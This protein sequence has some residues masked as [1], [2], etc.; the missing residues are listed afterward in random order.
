[1]LSEL[2][3]F[4]ERKPKVVVAIIIFITLIFASFI[5]SLKMG[6]STKDFVPDNEMVRA[7]DRINEYFGED[8]EPVMIILY[9][10]DVVSA[11]SIKAE[12]NI[13]K[14]LKEISGTEGVVGVA[15]FVSAICGMEYQKDMEECSDDEIRNAYND[16]M[17]PVSAVTSYDAEDS[18]YDFADITGFEMKACKKS[19]EIVFHVKNLAIPKFSSVEWYVSFKNKV[20]PAKLN[21]SYI[22]SCR[23][24]PP[25]WELGGGMKN[26]E[27]IKNFK[28]EKAEAF[29]WVGKDGKYMDFPLNAS[30]AID[31]HE[32]YMNISREELS[33]YGI[34]PSFGNASL[35]AKLY[36]MEAG[37]RVAVPF[38][39]SMN[40]GILY[41]II[42]LME[43]SF[44]ENLIMR[45]QQN[46]SFEMVEKLLE[47]KEAIS[48]NDFNNA[49]RNMD[50]VN[51][52]QQ[53]L[54]RQPVMDDLRN[55][56][57]MFLSSENGKAKATLMI[58]Q[59]NGSLDTNSL[60]QVS[61]KIV[62]VLEREAQKYGFKVEVTGSSVISYQIDDLTNK[63]NKIIIPSIFIAIILILFINF[64]RI[65][66]VIIS[67]LGLSLAIVWLFG[68]MALI[69]IKFNT[70]AIALVPLL[71]G[72]GVDYSVHI[73]HNYLHEI[74]NGKSVREAMILSIKEIG[75]ALILA[76]I[77]TAVSFLSFLSASIPSV[78][79]FG[80]L[81]AIGI[82]YTFIIAITFEAALR[83]LLDRGKEIEAKKS[84][85]RFSAGKI[86]E[87]LSDL[88]CK[89]PL[90][91]VAVVS[92]ITILMGA[93]AIN[94]KTS[95]SL[96]EFMPKDSEAIKAMEK[97]P[98]YFPSAGEDQE[99]ILLEGNVASVEAL[100]GIKKTME[101]IGDDVYV[102]KL[103]DGRVKADSIYS[104]MQDAIKENESL[105]EKFNVGNDGIPGSNEDVISFYNY[106]YEN[107]K[108]S[109]R[110]KSVL[111]RNDGKYDATVI[112]I[113]T[114]LTHLENSNEVMKRLYEDLKGDVSNYGNA[115]A[116]ITGSMVLIYTIM[117]SLT[118]SQLSS[119]IVCII[120]AAIVIIIAYRKPLL[121]L[122]TMIPVVIS[123]IWIM[124]TIY[125]AG[126]TLNVMTVMITSL[127][128][129]LGITYAIH[130]VE[131]FRLVAD[132]T[133]DVLHAVEEAIENTGQAVMM[134]AITT[135][136]GFI[137][138]IFSP[139]PPEQQ[140]GFLTA[141]TIIYSFLTTML[142]IPPLLLLWGK[143]RKKRKG[144]IISP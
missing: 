24:A 79:D 64:R 58:A 44:I 46:F 13:G 34:A 27:A 99:Y 57:L 112:R 130:V 41:W 20:D 55:S 85:S 94:V 33:K 65:S 56:A 25:Q 102:A 7:S 114:K 3:S 69:G 2:A 121:G 51:I 103:P 110:V 88:L 82:A 87:R 70:L 111:H 91:V 96:E 129:G 137:V 90:K 104:I 28:E 59:I 109:Q 75:L 76:T 139:M 43:N 48:L 107:E 93:A 133:G 52:E 84:E 81:A 101:N 72:L 31:E 120:I 1:M 35:P 115:K 14:K 73:F 21:L 49:W 16:L 4:I 61:R 143:W 77:T 122:L 45:F 38:P 135:V 29:I 15:N 66:Y 144:Y 60:K 6:T 83:Y 136:A 126:Y 105:K 132:K 118:K 128:I 22:I 95:F 8:E 36:D 53:L 89:N 138:L 78:R 54:I 68:T 42:K 50:S 30:I 67:L 5:P 23:T 127:T 37:S 86:M 26:I 19:V 141:T 106:L 62:S 39:F 98:K 11:D 100:K 116:T 71:M 32:I 108:F 142:M 74:G 140:F 80:I 17:N 18:K 12:Y 92:I 119:T 10:K 117:K 97:L 124:G 40:S 131:R 134:A 47:K 9:G 113:Y 125:I 63:S 123:S